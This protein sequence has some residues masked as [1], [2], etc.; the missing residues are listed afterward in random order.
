MRA[1]FALVKRTS[2][3]HTRLLIPER[4]P[5]VVLQQLAIHSPK[6]VHHALPHRRIVLVHRQHVVHEPHAAPPAAGV[7]VDDVPNVLPHVLLVVPTAGRLLRPAQVE[8]LRIIQR[9]RVVPFGWGAACFG[10]DRLQ[11]RDARRVFAR[12]GIFRPGA[13]R[14]PFGRDSHFVDHV[15][16]AAIRYRMNLALRINPLILLSANSRI[17]VDQFSFLVDFSYYAFC[18]RPAKKLDNVGG[19]Q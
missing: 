6:F 7:G 16:R 17:K 19:L 2:L 13:G 1:V 10:D 15:A 9:R 5:S 14:R 4:R 11:I 8:R 3:A 18:L 12:V